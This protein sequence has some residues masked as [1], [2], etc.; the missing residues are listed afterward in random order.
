MCLLFVVYM[1]S[2]KVGRKCL[3]LPFEVEVRLRRNEWFLLVSTVGLLVEGD[4]EAR[5]GLLFSIVS[6]SSTGDGCLF[7]LEARARIQML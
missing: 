3:A 7:L 2:W 6:W 5:F 1:S 4:A